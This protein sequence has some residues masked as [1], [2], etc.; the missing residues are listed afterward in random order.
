MSSEDAPQSPR[1]VAHIGLVLGPIAALGAVMLLPHT[2]TGAA[3]EAVEFTHAGRLTLAAMIWMAIWWLTEPVDIAGTA[4]LPVIIFPLLSIASINDAAAPFASPVIFLFAGSFLLALSMQRWGLDQ[5]YALMTLTLFG[6]RPHHMIGGFMVAAAVMSA[7]VSNTATTAMMLPMALGVIALVRTDR[8][9]RINTQCF[10]LAL[11]LGLAYAASIGGIATIIGTPPNA[12]LVGFLEDNYEISIG[13]AQWSAVAAPFSLLF[14][15]IAWFVI[16]RIL[17]KVE[18]SEMEGGRATMREKLVNLGRM[19]A[20]ER[21]TLFTFIVIA[22]LWMTR[23]WL[24]ELTWDHWKPLGGLS[25]A[26]IAMF[27]GM[28]LFFLPSRDPERPRVMD[29]SEVAKLPWRILILFGGGLSL[30]SAVKANGVA[31]FI[32]SFAGDLGTVPTIVLIVAVTTMV[33]F[34]TELT[35]NTATTAALLPVLAALATGFGMD[36]LLLLIPATVA[37][38]CAFMMPVA[39]PPNA[40]VFGSGYVTIPQMCRAGIWLNVIGVILITLFA[41]IVVV[42]V[43]SAVTV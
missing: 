19:N 13:F 21:W 39:T 11:L 35:S 16:T 31:E 9:A 6:T 37:A 26:G 33:I 24:T 22:L 29:W 7:F 25:D 18:T 40:I 27:G 17:F 5:R 23:P 12:L 36:P 41:Q 30:A 2:F 14:L 32:G 34:L 28:L 38:S 43:L 20:G 8:F 3:G 1:L 10:Q 15:V 4:L 42:R